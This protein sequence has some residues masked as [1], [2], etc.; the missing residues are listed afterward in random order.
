MKKPKS[1]NFYNPPKDPIKMLPKPDPDA[2]PVKKQYRYDRG[3]RHNFWDLFKE[4]E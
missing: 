1:K 3:P 4:E 2:I